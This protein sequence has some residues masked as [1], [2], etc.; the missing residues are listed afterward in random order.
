MGFLDEL[1]GNKD[2]Q[3]SGGMSPITLGLLALLAY[4]AYQSHT[5]GGSAPQPAPGSQDAGGAGSGGLG[6]ILGGLFGGRQGGPQTGGGGLNDLLRGGLGGLLGG[7]GAGTVLSGGLGN[8]L[9]QLQKAGHGDVAD[10]WVGKGANRQIDPRALEDAL[11]KDTLQ[12]L[13]QQTGRPYMDVLS[14]L[15]QSLP[16]TVDKMTP[17]G[18]LPTKSE[19]ETWT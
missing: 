6:D 19:A 1:F 17:Q 18:R 4:R 2:G 7:A 13:S 11:G 16:D 12:Q 5:Q 3:Q 10:S 9:E 15:S 8:L 14:E